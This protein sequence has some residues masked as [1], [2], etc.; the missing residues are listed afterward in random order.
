MEET[1]KSGIKNKTVEVYNT[2]IIFSRIMY[3][4]PAGHIQMEDL[5]KYEL[6]PVPTAKTQEKVDTLH[7][8]SL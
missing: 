4:L 8:K 6:P 5:F 2:E 7:Q 1:G 3:L